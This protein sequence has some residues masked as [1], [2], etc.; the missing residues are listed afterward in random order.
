MRCDVIVWKIRE[1]TIIVWYTV[2]GRGAYYSTP[3]KPW[4]KCCMKNIGESI[5]ANV[6]GRLIS[7]TEG[8]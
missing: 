5:L 4:S 1:K 2:V 8:A 7:S 6:G 3:F